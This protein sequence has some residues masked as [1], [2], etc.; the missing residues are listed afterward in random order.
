MAKVTCCSCPCPAFY[1]TKTGWWTCQNGHGQVLKTVSPD[2]EDY[3]RAEVNLV[4]LVGL[5]EKKTA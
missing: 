2:E 1:D 3:F 5:K 4:D